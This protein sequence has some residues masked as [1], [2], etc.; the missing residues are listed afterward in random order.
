MGRISDKGGRESKPPE[1]DEQ[2]AI[3]EG[4][5]DQSRDY[6]EREVEALYCDND[7]CEECGGR[8]RRL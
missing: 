4:L 5:E 1:P 7:E 2:A 8:L 3:S 6:Y